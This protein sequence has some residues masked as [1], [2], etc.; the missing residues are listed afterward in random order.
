MFALKINYKIRWPSQIQAQITKQE[1]ASVQPWPENYEHTGARGVLLRRKRKLPFRQQRTAAP[2]FIDTVTEYSEILTKLPP[3]QTALKCQGRHPTARALCRCFCF[4][5]PAC[6]QAVGLAL[7]ETSHYLPLR[8]GKTQTAKSLKNL[9][10]R[11]DCHI[12]A[13]GQALHWRL[14]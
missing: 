8:G 3:P 10:T 13:V 12:R 5:F 2:G 14:S 9:M 6:E 4:W 1:E 11:S 7:P